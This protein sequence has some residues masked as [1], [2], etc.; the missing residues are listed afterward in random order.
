MRDFSHGSM[1]FTDLGRHVYCIA[2]TGHGKSAILRNLV[3]QL[4]TEEAQRLYPCALVYIDPKGDDSLKMLEEA[5]D[6]SSSSSSP[7]AA[8]AAD[9]RYVLLDPVRTGFSVNPLELPPY[10]SPEDRERITS[11]YEGFFQS[12]LL[13][14]Y[15]DR[16]ADAPRMIRI[17]ETIIHALYQLED[18]PTF[19]DLHDVV[20]TLQRGDRAEVAKLMQRF[21]EVLSGR[22]EQEELRNAIQAVA[23]LRSEAFDPVLTRISKFATNSYLRKLFSTRRS[24]VDMSER[25]RPGRLTLVRVPASEI[26]AN[27]R[28]LIMS[29]VTLKIWFSVLLRTGQTTEEEGRT[30][31]ILMIDEFQN[32]QG[33]G[34]LQTMLAEARSHRLGLWLAHQNLAQVD[35]RLLKS[36]LGNTGTQ[37][38]GRLSG[39]DANRIASNW[40]PSLKQEIVQTLTTIPD[41]HFL[42]RELPPP[43]QEQNPPYEKT[44]CPPPAAVRSFSSEALKGFLEEMRTKYG[45]AK[46][47]R[48]IFSQMKEEIREWERLSVV[49][50]I[51]TKGAWKVLAALS[52]IE[53]AGFTKICELSGLPR[54]PE[55]QKVLDDLYDLGLIRVASSNAVGTRYYG[56]TGKAVDGILPPATKEGFSSIGG[57]DAQEIALAARKWYL[58]H[59][60]FFALARQDLEMKRKVDCVAFDYDNNTAAGVEIESPNHVSTHPEE[61]KAH[62]LEVE[63]FQELHVWVREE[64]KARVDELV[65]QLPADQKEKVRVFVCL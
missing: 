29:L 57:E 1:A 24:T 22:E 25:I 58:E 16:V 12:L 50:P 14:W 11:L 26:G 42:I 44:T 6:L 53:R 13:E 45:K 17:L 2:R 49:Q 21:N 19:I 40:D 23:E 64:S 54:T 30:P 35:D 47:E 5:P 9:D 59:G 51:P 37:I 20:T 63:P 7:S 3:H 27:V 33:L 41:Y 32:I 43:G 4:M 55:T 62:L 38:A 15:G 8:A 52:S 28:D 10:S 46:V 61:L 60:W 36:I 65:D 48:S 56:L 34:V 18:A 39:E 31:V